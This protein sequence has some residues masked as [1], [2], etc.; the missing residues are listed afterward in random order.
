[1]LMTPST[2]E[3]HPLKLRI[4][5][6]EVLERAGV[7][8]DYKKA[9]LIDGVIEVMNAEFRC[10]NFIKNEVTYR[11]R[12]AFEALDSDLSAYNEASLALPSHSLPQADVVVAKGGRDDRYY[13]P[14]DIAIV[15]E[16]ADSTA[17]RD[18]TVKRVLYAE[19]GI[20]EYWVIEVST[21]QVHQ[22]WSVENGS[23]VDTRSMPVNREIGSATMPELTIDGRGIL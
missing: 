15:I 3:P 20:A 21:G 9:E 19:G 4:E 18:L 13:E 17:K 7:F 22:F 2:T 16:V 6:F 11:L 23:Y 10:H 12:R 14:A 1:M 8:K 5:D